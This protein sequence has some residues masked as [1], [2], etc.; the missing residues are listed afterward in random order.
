MQVGF[1][2]F[3]L[4]FLFSCLVR[5]YHPHWLD[6]N[7]FF[8]GYIQIYIF[9]LQYVNIHWCSDVAYVFV[10]ITRNSE[11][12]MRDI[13]NRE[14]NYQKT[15]NTSYGT[16]NFFLFMQWLLV[17]FQAPIACFVDNSYIYNTVEWISMDFIYIL[18][19]NN[20]YQKS[21]HAIT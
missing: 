14:R 13:F 5:T 10:S 4:Y 20:T 6:V 8:S 1:F 18:L 12:N 9:L 21:S 11:N 2:F 16:S 17:A 15:A 19:I 3:F 7:M